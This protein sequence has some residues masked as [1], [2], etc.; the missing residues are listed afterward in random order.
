MLNFAHDPLATA[1]DHDTIA[2]YTAEFGPREWLTV[3]FDIDYGHETVR[4]VVNLHAEHD[5]YLTTDTRDWPAIEAVLPRLY[6]PTDI[7][8][9]ARGAHP[10]LAEFERQ[11]HRFAREHFA[12]MR[13]DDALYADDAD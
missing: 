8:R 4:S 5:D 11:A 2:A 6:W 7:H 1:Y 9:T 10:Q 13:A 3:Y 12:A